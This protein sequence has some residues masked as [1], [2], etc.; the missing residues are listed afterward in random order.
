MELTL[1]TQ[2]LAEASFGTLFTIKSLVLANTILE[3]NL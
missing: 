2:T 1:G 3:S